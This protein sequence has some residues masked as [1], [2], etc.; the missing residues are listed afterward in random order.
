MWNGKFYTVCGNKKESE[1]RIRFAQYE[2][3]TESVQHMQVQIFKQS[4]SPGTVPWSVPWP[5]SW[6]HRGALLWWMY[7]LSLRGSGMPVLTRYERA[8]NLQRW[9][10]RCEACL[11]CFYCVLTYASPLKLCTC[12]CI[13]PPPVI[14]REDTPLVWKYLLPNYIE[15][16]NFSPL[17]L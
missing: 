8:G 11:L 16:I 12:V 7:L 4:L 2:V 13:N 9:I 6:S 3:S 5:A 1:G 17:S 14:L 15:T 10:S